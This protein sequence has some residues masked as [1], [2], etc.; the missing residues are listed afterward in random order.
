V[1]TGSGESQMQEMGEIPGV[2]GEPKGRGRARLAREL[3]RGVYR[4]GQVLKLREIGERYE[5]GEDTLR[6]AFADLES[7]GVVKLSENHSATVLSPSLKE[8]MEAY[9]IRAELEE[10]TGR[11]AA[12]FL[13]G[14]TAV[15][16]GEV[17]AM[18]AA[19]RSDDLD[20]YAE[21]DIKFHRIILEASQNGILR[22]VWDT[23]AIDLLMRAA[24]PRVTRDLYDTAESHRPIAK[25]LEEGRGRE[26]GLLLRNHVETVLE[27]LKRSEPDS[28]VQRTFRRDLEAAKEVQQAFFPRQTMSIPCTSCETFYQPARGIG[29]D[30]YD[31]LSLQKGRW[32]IAIGDV[33]GK[34]I[35]AALI[36]ASLQA[37]LKFQAL[38]P[39]LKLSTLIGDVN[40][41]V[42]GSSPK[43]IFATLF[44]AEYEPAKRL[45][46]YVN[47]GHNPPL[48]LRPNNGSCEIFQLPSTGIPVGISADS[49]FASTT[50]QFEIDDVLIAYTDGITETENRQHELWGQQ[51]LVALLKSC[52]RKSPTEI[53]NAIL[54]QVST[55]AN[56]EPQ[57]DDVTVLVMRVEAGCDDLAVSAEP[58][59]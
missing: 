7:L 17:D 25:A 30:Y 39:H 10:I 9:E 3:F 33:S 2:I 47:A 5:L 58:N 37:S 27:Y 38:Q 46:H 4:P 19:V 50:F 52:S 59:G 20:A 24:I 49:Q 54:D 40:R 42:Y 43:N 28:G 18:L 22:Q 53:I 45:L 35:G 57:R 26:A 6:N 23:L 31:L 15:L 14:N 8:M 48:I 41:L 32:G 12:A 44:Y 51:R 16:Q 34:G 56:G 36:M 55:F 29:G 21:H 13:E 11:T 1:N